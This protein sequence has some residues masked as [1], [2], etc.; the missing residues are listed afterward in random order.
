VRGIDTVI[1][2]QPEFFR[3]VE[4]SLRTRDLETW[5]TYLR[6][7]LAHTFA[8]QAGGRFDAED[9]HFYG[10][11]LNGTRSSGRAGS[12]C[13]TRRRTTSGTR[14]GQL[15][16]ERYFSPRT[17]ARYERLTDE[18][19]D[20]FRAPHPRTRMDER[21]HQGARAAQA[22]CGDEEGGLPERWRD[23]S[24]YEVSRES[25]LGNCPARQ[26][27][28]ERTTTSPSSTSRSIAPSGR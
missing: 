20:A 1:V 25:F 12:A 6:W 3:Q 19:F 4:R 10:T 16:V 14:S 26:H 2:G 24:A 21:L 5:K 18:I 22:R 8:A 17:K 7:H 23:Y 11:V 9:F 15:Y 13:S 27:L 28:A